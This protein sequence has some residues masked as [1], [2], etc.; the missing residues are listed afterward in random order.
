[1][2]REGQNLFAGYGFSRGV[3]AQRSPPE[4]ALAIKLRCASHP[5][6]MRAHLFW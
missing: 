4:N 3:I 5:K 6:T 2:P 1:M